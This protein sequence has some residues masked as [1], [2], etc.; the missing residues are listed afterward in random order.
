[1]ERA[2]G[3]RALKKAS[4]GKRMLDRVRVVQLLGERSF[5]GRSDIET[6][7]KSAQLR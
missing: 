3:R 2:K 6:A 1:M 7:F 4:N 5:Q